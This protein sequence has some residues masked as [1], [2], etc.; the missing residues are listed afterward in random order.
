MPSGEKQ[1]LLDEKLFLF[2]RSSKQRGKPSFSLMETC[3]Q[4]KRKR[5]KKNWPGWPT[6]ST[7]HP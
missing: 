3:S 6:R 4:E 1:L 2:R 5:K 7:I